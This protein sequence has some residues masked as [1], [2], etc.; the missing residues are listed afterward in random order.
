MKTRQEAFCEFIR[1]QPGFDTHMKDLVAIGNKV[2]LIR[3]GLITVEW[4]NYFNEL[5]EYG[6]LFNMTE[7]YDSTL[8]EDKHYTKIFTYSGITYFYS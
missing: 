1:N 4:N 5:K 3:K 7:F 8:I 6:S 2:F